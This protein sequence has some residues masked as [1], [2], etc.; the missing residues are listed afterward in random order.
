[1]KFSTLL[2]HVTP[3]RNTLVLIVLLLLA[4]SIVSLANPWIAGQLTRSILM[5]GE[6]LHG[7]QVILLAWLGLL[8]VRSLL[9]FSSQY[10]VGITAE[11]MSARL[12]N[13]VYEH[14]QIL[15]LAYHQERRQDYFGASGLRS[16]HR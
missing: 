8:A 10:L 13:R 5:P 12:R 11:A 14:L 16:A 7:P 3:H 4:G 15:P 2:Q 9:G 1:M 6:S